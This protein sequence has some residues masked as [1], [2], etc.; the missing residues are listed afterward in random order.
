MIWGRPSP[1]PPAN[2]DAESQN[3]KIACGI[4]THVQAE[5]VENAAPGIDETAVR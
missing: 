2:S 4:P 5:M 1:R 3:I